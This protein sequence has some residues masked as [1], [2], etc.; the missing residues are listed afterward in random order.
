MAINLGNDYLNGLIDQVIDPIE[1]SLFSSIGSDPTI[2]T[3]LPAEAGIRNSLSFANIKIGFPTREGNIPY[4]NFLP[5][6][7]LI[8]PAYVTRF[9]DNFRVNTS[10]DTVY[11]RTDPIPRYKGVTRSISVSLDIPCFDANDA[12]ENLKKIN[13]FIYNLYPSYDSFKGDLVI[14]SPPLVRVKFANL[15]SNQLRGFGGLLGYIT[16][17]TYN[18]DPRDGFLFSSAAGQS[19]TTN[20]FFRSYRLSFTFTVLHEEVVGFV[21]GKPNTNRDY[22]Y[23]TNIN[24]FN[25]FNLPSRNNAPISQAQ[26]EQ[27]QLN[28]G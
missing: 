12:N 23:Q 16:N 27:E 6:N 22:P 2:K 13:K 19:N 26:A 3:A 15:I 24:Q 28:N 10:G 17:F 18:V 21:N 14:S 7:S 1:N 25:P 4:L 20:L 11:G 5:T 8:F 9:Q